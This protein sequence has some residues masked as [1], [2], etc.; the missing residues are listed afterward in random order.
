MKVRILQKI[1]A[2]GCSRWYPQRKFLWWWEA[3]DDSE[4]S[5]YGFPSLTHCEEHLNARVVATIVHEVQR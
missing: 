3:Y 5:E 2:K 4:Y 1:N